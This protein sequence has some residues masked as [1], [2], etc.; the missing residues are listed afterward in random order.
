MSQAEYLEWQV[1]DVLEPIGFRRDDH[2]AAW[3]AQWAVAPHVKEMPAAEK[4]MPFDE[5]RFDDDDEEDGGLDGWLAAASRIGI[6]I[7]TEG[8]V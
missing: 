7:V 6:P 1:F 4:F 8:A 3:M 5:G 2:L